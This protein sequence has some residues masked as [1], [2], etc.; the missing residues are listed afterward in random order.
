MGMDKPSS[1][2]TVPIKVNKLLFL[3]SPAFNSI[4]FAF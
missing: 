1:N 4:S 2:T 3:I